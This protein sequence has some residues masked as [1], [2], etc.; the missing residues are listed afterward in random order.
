MAP[1]ELMI[2]LATEAINL[3]E[4]NHAIALMKSKQL[5]DNVVRTLNRSSGDN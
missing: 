4:F 1:K 3:R 5:K 2:P